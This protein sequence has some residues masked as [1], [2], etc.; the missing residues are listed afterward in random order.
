[1]TFEQLLEA[2]H[3]RRL[4]REDKFINRVEKQEAR[5]AAMVGQLASGKFYV[6]P[7][8]GTYREGTE[9]ELISFLVRNHCV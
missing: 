3:L 9:S 5:A 2:K 4:R 7:V 6:Y 8:G 1:M